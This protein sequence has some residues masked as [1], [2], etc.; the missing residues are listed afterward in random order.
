MQSAKKTGNESNSAEGDD[1]R[2]D[3]EDSLSNDSSDSDKEKFMGF[4]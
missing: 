3:E 2:E 4:F 1:T